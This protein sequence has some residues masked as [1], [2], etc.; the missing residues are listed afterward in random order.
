MDLHGRRATN[1]G[2][3]IDPQD[4]VT[5]AQLLGNLRI[6]RVQFVGGPNNAVGQRRCYHLSLDA[7]LAI[8]S[9]ITSETYTTLTTRPISVRAQVKYAPVGANVTVKYYLDASLW[10]TLVILDGTKFIDATAGQ[11]TAAGNIA[12]GK[13]WKLDITTVGTTTPGSDLSTVIET[14]VV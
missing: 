2:D 7:N 10:M 13:T 1:A 4:Y 6:L 14:E 12:A 5:L 8:A 9:N 3:A 11:I